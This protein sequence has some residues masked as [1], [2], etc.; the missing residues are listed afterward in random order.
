M[1]GVFY[2][3]DRNAGDGE[4][5]FWLLKALCVR[6]VINISPCTII[7][8]IFYMLRALWAAFLISA[9][10]YIVTFITSYTQFMSK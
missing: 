1:N 4:R 3:M 10:L 7:A 2:G 5:I 6:V 8:V 9:T